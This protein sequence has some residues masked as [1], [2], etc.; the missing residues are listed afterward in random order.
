[1]ARVHLTHRALRSL[2][3][4]RLQEDFWDDLLAGFGVR[5][6]S[7]GR[8][9]FV[10]RYRANGRKRRISIGTYPPWSLADARDKAKEIL[11][12]TAKG[13]DP[14]AAHKRERAAETFGELAADYLERHA[15]RRKKSWKEDQ[16]KIDIELL[17][18]WKTRKAKDVSR[19]DVIRLVEGIVERGSP[20]S[21][22]RTLALISK[23]FNFGIEQEA[24]ETNPAQR[25]KPPTREK[26]RDRV[27][28]ENEIQ[29]LWRALD[30]EH[31]VVAGTFKLRLL[32]AQRGIEVLSMRWSDIDGEWWTIPAEAS[33]N[34][35][36]HRVPLSPQALAILEQLRPLTGDSEWV[37]T[38][39]KKP[40][41]H[42]I[43]V[44]KATLRIAAKAGVEFTAHDLRRTAATHMASMGVS[45]L[46]I[47]KILNHVER[48]ITAI[49]DRASYDAEK[50]R[51]LL[52]WGE[53][54]ERIGSGSRE[55]AGVVPIR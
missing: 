14:Q 29:A 37:F 46:T 42:I 20:V 35:L 21:A 32:T 28:K 6:A 51:A 50:R 3:T 23:I 22:N 40:G 19:R 16:R 52:R 2:S 43:A 48:G 27:L 25:V 38:S 33:K 53:K 17:P 31:P 55:L 7:S 41:F 47:S 12:Q 8:K 11:G 34:A 36:P 24:V 18:A 9:T 45:R 44:R 10:L 26:S 4:D 39:P 54:V 1:M 49:Y 30:D 15:K 13:E 5:I